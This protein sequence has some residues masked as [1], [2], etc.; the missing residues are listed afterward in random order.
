MR[1]RD[2][3]ALAARYTLDWRG[4]YL[5]G[6]LSLLSVLGLVFA[7]ALLTL[8]L[9]VMNGFDREMRDNILA[10]V[11]QL[12]VRAW[13]PQAGWRD[14][15]DLIAA[16]PEVK[17]VTPFVELEGMLVNGGEAESALLSGVPADGVAALLARVVSNDGG[18]RDFR[19]DPQGLLLGSA[20]ADGLG[21]VPGDAVTLIV[22]GAGPDPRS[23]FRPT[24]FQHLRLSGLVHTG[25][26]LDQG[27]AFLHMETA[28]GLAGRPGEVD[29]YRVQL[30][31]LFRAPL[32]GWELVAQ[33]P[34][35]FYA[36]DWTMTHGNL[37]AAIQMSK[38]MVSLLLFSVIA[39]AAFNVVSS[40]VLVV[41]DKRPDIAILR[42][43]GAGPG[44]INGIFIRQGLLIAATGM[45]LGT[46]LGVLG[47][48]WVTEAVRG[49][50]SLLGFRFLNTDV[51]PIGYMPS[52]LRWADVL[53]INAAALLLC[54]LA[55]LYPAHRASRMAPAEALRHD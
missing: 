53:L 22:P 27:V 14:A 25:T 33:L 18:W 1:S 29:G 51:Y 3:L 35:S 47:S 4:G 16:H 43:M 38:D 44:D 39:I 55:S 26:E 20:L 10:T 28:A 23:T 42:A 7:V 13:E 41:V 48:L 5:S 21:L 40:L 30:D 12:T 9:S 46:G 49:L 17:S 45:A 50:E 24:R 52:D 19:G 11:P 2:L 37:Y 15:A 54:F 6:V 31:N 34:P 8:V 32:V 36:R